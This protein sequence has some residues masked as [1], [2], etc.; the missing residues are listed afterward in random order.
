MRLLL[1]PGGADLAQHQ[2]SGLADLVDVSLLEVAAGA[3]AFVMRSALGE[4]GAHA[5]R[6]SWVRRA[7]RG[8]KIMDRV[9]WAL[10]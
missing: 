7:G 8:S 6:R 4:C 5:E 9:R 2:S 1:T 10:G 3:P